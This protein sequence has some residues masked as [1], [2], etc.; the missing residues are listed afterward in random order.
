M[1]LARLLLLTTVETVAL[2][3]CSESRCR[4][5]G[6]VEDEEYQLRPMNCPF[7][8]AIYNVRGPPAPCPS[9]PSTPLPARSQRPRMAHLAQTHFTSMQ[10]GASAPAAAVAA[11]VVLAA[12]VQNTGAW[13]HLCCLVGPSLTAG[14]SSC[15]PHSKQ[16]VHIRA[17]CPAVEAAQLQG[18]AQAVGGAGHGV[19]LRALRHHA[20]PV[21]RPR[22]HPGGPSGSIAG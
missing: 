4:L 14:V 12:L 18:A 5:W 7:H 16:H 10:R 6:Q 11:A 13:L 2:A 20:R 22:L 17:W 9:V 1:E 3:Q 15:L 19:P 21:P 8:I